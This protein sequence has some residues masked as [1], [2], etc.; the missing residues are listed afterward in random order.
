MNEDEETLWVQSRAAIAT[1]ERLDRGMGSDIVLS[2]IAALVLGG[3]LFKTING[4]L[5]SM[6]HF[7]DNDPGNIYAAAIGVVGAAIFAMVGFGYARWSKKRR[8]KVFR[9]ETVAAVENADA[10]TCR[11]ALERLK[12]AMEHE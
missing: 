11:D 9:K 12:G 7:G 8:M 2:G 6:E 3:V 4:S 5:L 10:V 1:S